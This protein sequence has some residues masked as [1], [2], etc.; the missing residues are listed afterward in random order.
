MRAK[1]I[2]Y[3]LIT[4]II[5]L[6]S[7]AGANIDKI[8]KQGT[9]LQEDYK[10][11]IPFTYDSINDWIVL[12]VEIR[13][14]TYNFIL[15][16]GS[17][18]IITKE[19]AAELDVKVLGAEEI[20]DTNA[21]SNTTEFTRVN[22]IK[23][24]GINFQNTIAGIVDLNK[25]TALSCAKIDGLI[26]SNLMRKA[27]WDFDFQNQ[28]ITIT[29]GEDKLDIPTQT[30]DTRLYIGAAGV[31]AVTLEINGEKVLN[32]TVDFGNGGNNILRIDRFQEQLDAN[33]ISKYV[34]GSK[35]SF[36]AFGHT[37]NQPYYYTII[38]EFKIGNH[39]VN[40]LITVVDDGYSN[41]LGLA[42]FKNYRII[43]NWKK[44]RM[45]MIEVTKAGNNSYETYGFSILYEGEETY[46]NGIVEGSSASQYLIQGDKILHINDTSYVN[47]TKEQRCANLANDFGKET[48]SLSIT[49][50]RE[51]KEL[52]FEILKT[53]LL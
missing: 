12:E 28:L 15:D 35:K 42:F 48:G 4:L 1:K 26:G 34:K 33:L 38:D 44:K 37:E 21:T 30:I 23:I 41:K 13:G 22:S 7:C 31:P 5:L 50:L 39:T 11:T 3:L 25:T 29:S 40:N 32:N 2:F 18:N 20:K 24:G 53:K 6:S 10:T 51:G 45:R 47:N 14:K 17:S 8:L 43:L 49:I 52:T 36:G 9:V 46:V 16:T 19:L 27:I